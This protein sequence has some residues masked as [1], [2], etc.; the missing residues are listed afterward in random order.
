MSADPKK[1]RDLFQSVGTQASELQAKFE[2]GDYTSR[3]LALL[4]ELFGKYIDGLDDLQNEGID[5][6]I[7]C[8]IR[9]EGKTIKFQNDHDMSEF[10]ADL[11][12]DKNATI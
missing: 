9:V 2:S 11:M 7:P 5:V 1:Y 3:D 6:A 8:V 12:G 10:I 4:G